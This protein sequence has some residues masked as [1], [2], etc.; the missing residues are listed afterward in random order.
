MTA[1]FVFLLL[2]AALIIA[3]DTSTGRF[4]RRLMVEIPAAAAGRINR[5]HGA[6]LIV[7]LLLV[8]LCVSTGDTDPFRLV[9]I[10]AP[11]LTIWLANVEISAVL[12]AAASV[13]IAWAVMRR[14][15]VRTVVPT[16]GFPTHAAYKA[17]RSRCSRRVNHRSPAND[18]DDRGPLALA[19]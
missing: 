2:W 8:I 5:A 13:A 16:R 10:Y 9:G 6:V 19:S 18:D 7:T 11:D 14:V 1:L 12:D 17:K 15:I 4:L 3:E